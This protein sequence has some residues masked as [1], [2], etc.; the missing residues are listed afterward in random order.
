[1]K[2]LKDLLD[3]YEG[4][5]RSRE[6]LG[7]PI[8]TYSNWAKHEAKKLK[9]EARAYGIR[10]ESMKEGCGDHGLNS[11]KLPTSYNTSIAV[12]ITKEL[13]IPSKTGIRKRKAKRQEINEWRLAKR[14]RPG[15]FI[16][17]TQVIC[18]VDCDENE[19]ND[20]ADDD[21]EFFIGT[22]RTIVDGYVKVHLT[23]LAKKDDIWLE[24]DSDHLFLDGGLTDPPESNN[25]TPKG[26]GSQK[27]KKVHKYYLIN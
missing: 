4:D 10:K 3:S 17:N 24:Q 23:G 21:V 26:G 2:R 7:M 18:M 5:M 14:V 9:K 20:S 22:V 1:M 11:L 12:E 6:A 19:N 25:A 8:L 13:Y 27:M 16:P 15:L